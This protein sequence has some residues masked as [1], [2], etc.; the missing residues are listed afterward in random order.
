MP[1][2]CLEFLSSM[3]QYTI[4]ARSAESFDHV[5]V[6]RKVIIGGSDGVFIPAP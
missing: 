6:W 4:A 2:H 5:P 3:A 1:F